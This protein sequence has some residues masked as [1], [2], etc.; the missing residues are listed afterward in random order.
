VEGARDSG[1]RSWR[2]KGKE[3]GIQVEGARGFP[4]T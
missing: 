3:L 4:N 2:L 1:G